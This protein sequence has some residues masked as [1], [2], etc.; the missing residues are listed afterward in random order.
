MRNATT[1]IPPA[2]PLYAT[3]VLSLHLAASSLTE[4]ELTL[5]TGEAEDNIRQALSL[6][7]RAGIA[8][9][10]ED[11]TWVCLDVSAA[12]LEELAA[13]LRD[14]VPP[15]R[16]A[17]SLGRLLADASLDD[18]EYVVQ[19]L[20]AELKRPTPESLLCLEFVVGYLLR[21]EEGHRAE[22]AQK[23]SQY[24]ELVLV[25]QSM[26]LFLHSQLQMAA[27][28]SPIAYAM[29]EVC[30]NTR[31]RPL[32]GI[33][34]C[35]MR[36]FTDERLPRD[37]T[38]YVEEVDLA[39]LG[40]KDM[41][42][43][44]PLFKGILH[45][46]RG[47]FG[48]VL[49]CYEQKR[50]SYGWK[51]R[52][53]AMLLSSCA[54]QSAFYLRRYHIS[55]GIN[56]SC[57][58]TAAL[59]GDSLLS[60]FWMLHLGFAMLR[61]GDMDAA[62]LNLDCLFTAVP[63]PRDNK[64]S[65]GAVRGIALYHYLHGRLR[66]AHALL[67]CQAGRALR[68]NT[69]HA[70]FEDPLNLD[71]LYA[72]EQEGFPPVPRYHLEKSLEKILDGPNRHLRGAALRIAALR[73]RDQGGDRQREIALLRESRALLAATGDQREYALTAHEL[74]NA[75]ER[76][77]KRGEANKLR[78]EVAAYA[79]CALDA[80]VSYQKA[81]HLL[82]CEV[83]EASRHGIPAPPSLL[84]RCSEAFNALST[85]TSQE[86]ALSRLA[87]I[88]Q[89]ELKSERAALFRSDEEGGLLCVASI[90]LTRMELESEAMRPCMSWLRQRV[91]DTPPHCLRRGRQGLCLPLNIGESYPWLFYLDSTFTDGGFAQLDERELHPLSCL[92]ASEVR[93]A[94][95][96]KRVRDE[97]SR[98]QK[99]RFQSVALQ[100]DRNITPVF[101]S[102][103]G[104]VLEQVRQVSVTDAPVLILGETGVG[105]EVVA[106]QI[107]QM[108]RRSGPFIAVHP[109]S[110]PENLFESE[111]FGHERGAFT[112]AAH[113]KLGFFE[114]ADEG[115]LFIDE[116]GDIPLAI[117]VKLLRVL[118]EQ[119]FMRVGGTREIHS[120]F[121][122]IA[123][124]NKDL[125]EEVEK[126]MFREDLLYRI[127]VVPL[128]LPPLRERK[129]DILLLAQS[130]MEHFSRRYNRP[131]LRLS[132]E[133]MENL[134]NYKWPGNVRELKNVIERAVILNEYTPLDGRSAA[135]AAPQD[136]ARL[137][138]D[139]TPTLEE[140]ERRY[141]EHLLHLTSG[142]IYGRN[143]VM[144]R[145][146]IKR[147]TLYAKLKKHGLSP[148]S[149]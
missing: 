124:T 102:G 58:R 96:L 36:I 39:D 133:E 11:G 141:L 111:F 110:T 67:T 75:L 108:S 119:Q 99:E 23:S 70:P 64:T 89:M 88:V 7:E 116:V 80:A 145:L 6:L 25:V 59:D 101:G 53:F 48:E 40:D 3:L 86:D 52:R 91:F 32:V 144:E 55:L 103:L 29:T 49:R 106:R 149:F 21:W 125:W 92:F 61:I 95:R 68:R 117:Q 56:E 30:G 126:G 84:E 26:C 104:P 79:G 44:L 121:R 115:T 71:M 33:F 66:P 77:G 85:E 147:S 100:E 60:M 10:R 20:D 129:E 130:F 93:S 132:R 97:E 105:K 120:R 127:S 28:L 73:L 16:T 76:E 9:R 137:I 47:E 62:I 12:L 139:D 98:H 142:S 72:F 63:A 15:E 90:N 5:L 18:C 107:H 87:A 31:F 37:I 41:Q 122:L 42:E 51:Y 131:V 38:R 46:V 140:L 27:K 78:R 2:E 8:A 135:C 82:T 114:M 138:V 57:R 143:G 43:R 35:Y 4:K 22:A 118:Q 45:F 34:A 109:A 128:R 54:S 112:G 17:H 24:A 1:L 50:D 83:P 134:R 136:P 14:R 69:P 123:A 148:S 19:R 113:Q 13:V 65:I 81:V 146:N 74:A 94:L